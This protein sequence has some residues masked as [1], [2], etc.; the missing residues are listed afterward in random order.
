MRAMRD[1][2]TLEVSHD[3]GSPT[4]TGGC[5][6]GG[7]KVRRMQLRKVL[8]AWQQHVSSRLQVVS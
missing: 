2:H 8:A 5:D 6:C 7:Y 3:D 1:G 4:Y